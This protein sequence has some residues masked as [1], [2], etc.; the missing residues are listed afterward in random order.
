MSA[1]YD[2]IDQK[3]Q[4]GE[5]D[6]ALQ[7]IERESARSAAAGPESEWSFRILKAHVFIYRAEYKK[8]LE[9]LND[10]L[11]PRSGQA[12]L[13]S[14]RIFTR[15]LLIDWRSNTMNPRKALGEGFH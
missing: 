9:I 5:L 3:I 13:L 6:A 7:D 2:R 14:A 12:R 1:V 4:H 10:P 11:P 8:T 15:Q